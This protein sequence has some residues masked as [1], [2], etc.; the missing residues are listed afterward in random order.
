MI[1]PKTPLLIK[2][3]RQSNGIEQRPIPAITTAH[4]QRHLQVSRAS[5]LW[6][7]DSRFSRFRWR[8]LCRV[9]S[10]SRRAWNSIAHRHRAPLA[11]TENVG[12]THGAL[13]AGG[14][15]V[16]YLTKLDVPSSSLSKFFNLWYS[17]CTRCSVSCA[18]VRPEFKASFS[19]L[20]LLTSAFVCCASISSCR[21]AQARARRVTSG[22]E[23]AKACA[24]CLR[25]RSTALERDKW[26]S[27]CWE[28][29]Y[30]P[31]DIAQLRPFSCEAL[32][33][34]GRATWL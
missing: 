11:G 4:V 28:T 26:D 5:S 18:L 21:A 24:A 23:V 20:S 30:L 34:G 2:M 1:T 33:C 15:V 7:I 29:T 16:V 25:L 19:D 31:D 6:A 8:S 17:L 3:S 13:L 32:C 9:S 22:S 27:W 10:A 12:P 14:Q